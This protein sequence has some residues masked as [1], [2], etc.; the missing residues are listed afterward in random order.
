MFPEKRAPMDRLDG[1]FEVGCELP[2]RVS[3]LVCGFVSGSGENK[4]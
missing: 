1:S 2:Q 4:G 3:A